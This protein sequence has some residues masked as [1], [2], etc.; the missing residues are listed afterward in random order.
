MTT[1]RVAL[2]VVALLVLLA[3]PAAADESTPAET[4]ITAML[5]GVG[6]VER[7]CPVDV[8]ERIEQREMRVVC[9]RFEGDFNSFESRWTLHIL[10]DAMFDNNYGGGTIPPFEARTG[11]EVSGS[12]YDRIYYIGQ[13]TLGVRFTEG[14][15]LMVYK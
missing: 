13:S 12:T 4:F 8:R 1:W 10:Q 11:W 2:T 3:A 7:Q 6:A 14:E 5:E 15:I 9:A